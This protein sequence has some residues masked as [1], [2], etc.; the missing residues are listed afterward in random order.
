MLFRSDRR[1]N[2]FL[3]QRFCLLED[4]VLVK[5]ICEVCYIHVYLPRF[6]S[7]FNRPNRAASICNT[8]PLLHRL[9]ALRYTI[10]DFGASYASRL[11]AIL[12]IVSPSSVDAIQKSSGYYHLPIL[13]SLHFPSYC[14]GINQRK[15]HLH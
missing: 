4:A 14:R 3:P 15:Y 11:S 13:N 2:K 1:L 6:C 7:S 5:K 10:C 8:M 9:H 12:T